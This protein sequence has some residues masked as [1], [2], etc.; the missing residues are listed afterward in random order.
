MTTG[1]R[2]KAQRKK[3][4]L[5]Q[6]ELAARLGVKSPTVAQ[7][8]TGSRNPKLVTLQKIAWALGC[9]IDDLLGVETFDTGEEFDAAWKEF[10]KAARENPEGE[11]LVVVYPTDPRK[12]IEYAL[13][14]MNEEGIIKM[15]ER[16]EEVLQV[17]K[18]RK[19]PSEWV[20]VNP[21]YKKDPPTD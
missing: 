17:P 20:A 13:G 11:S 4:G 18:Y 7:W 21:Q 19:N 3:K 5:T 15:A 8:E 6:K 16:A 1:E 2:I 9:S 10:A 12:F 14:K